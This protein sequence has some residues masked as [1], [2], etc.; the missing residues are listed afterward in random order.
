MNEFLEKKQDVLDASELTGPRIYST[1]LHPH[2]FEDN[3]DVDR[4]LR[5]AELALK[6]KMLTR[7]LVTINGSHFASPI[8]MRFIEEHQDDFLTSTA[9]RTAYRAD[10]DNG[11]GAFIEEYQNEHHDWYKEAGIGD[12]QLKEHI[13]YLDTKVERILPWNPEGVDQQYRETVLNGLNDENSLVRARLL[14]SK[15]VNSKNIDVLRSKIQSENLDLSD[16]NAMF[17]FMM[18]QPPEIQRVL[19]P[20]LLSCYHVVGLGVVNCEAGTDLEPMASLKADEALLANSEPN[21]DDELSVFKSFFRAAIT[22][23]GAYA[24][25]TWFL[26]DLKF[27][28]AAE[29]GKRLHSSGFSK[30]YDRI[31][32]AYGEGLLKRTDENAFAS[33]DLPQLAADISNLD[34]T[35]RTEIGREL[36][37]ILKRDA[38]GDFIRSSRDLF[39]S[40]VSLVVSPIGTVFGAF[41]LFR[42]G[43]KTV[44]E[45]IEA[46]EAF[47]AEKARQR[48]LKLR[49]EDIKNLIQRKK[50]AK[51]K[52]LGDVANLLA[53]IAHRRQQP[54]T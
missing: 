4:A 21:E 16:D 33:L 37:S 45:G 38:I 9:M 5:R 46:I 53:D 20:F 23:T 29:I 44:R 49:D 50:I 39:V 25:P 13:K 11:F 47:D 40:G 28:D 30:S 26:E 2:S 54:L 6:A 43:G 51:G 22:A 48:A 42:T 18:R 34:E 8:G 32:S 31:L 3:E 12:A 1:D 14:G 27:A 35:F 10:R 36:D 17:E 19:R 24:T 7:G 52:E 15:T 41:D